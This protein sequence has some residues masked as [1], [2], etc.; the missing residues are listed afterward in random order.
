MS[1]L[2]SVWHVSD[3]GCTSITAHDRWE[4]DK[5]RFICSQA[6]KQLRNS[7]PH[8]RLWVT[9]TGKQLWDDA[10]PGQGGGSGQPDLEHTLQFLS[11]LHYET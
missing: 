1:R 4:D 5:M 9:E 2:T 8:I 3:C 10:D 6:T 11:M 7:T